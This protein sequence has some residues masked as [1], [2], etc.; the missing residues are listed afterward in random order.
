ML[1]KPV[2]TKVYYYKCFQTVNYRWEFVTMIYI[3]RSYSNCQPF[4]ACNFSS[5]SGMLCTTRES[6]LLSIPAHASAILFRSCERSTTRSRYTMGLRY[7]HSQKSNGDKSG[8]RGGQRKSKCR[9]TEVVL[10]VCLH[11]STNVR[12]RAVLLKPSA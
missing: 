1:I 12:W 2:R 11:F 3:Y 4:A 8:D 5:R 10:Q 9:L 7:P 6:I